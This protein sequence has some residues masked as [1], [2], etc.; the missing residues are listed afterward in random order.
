MND[1]PEDFDFDSLRIEPP[2][3]SVAPKKRKSL[4]HMPGRKFLK[5]PIPLDH[6]TL[7]ARADGKA[8][9]V[10]LALWFYVGLRHSTQVNF[11]VGWLKTAFGVG[12]YAAYRG[13]AALEK[14][15]LVTVVRCRGRASLVTLLEVSDVPEVLEVPDGK[16]SE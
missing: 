5:G 13:L 8:L 2:T 1:I 4:R 10:A 3:L 9:H 6:L 14:A 16:R 11:P 7:A 12:R 15:G